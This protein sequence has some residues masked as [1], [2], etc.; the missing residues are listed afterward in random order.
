MYSQ[1]QWHGQPWGQA[2]AGPAPAAPLP[3]PWQHHA[4]GQAGYRLG[5]PSSSLSAP[6]PPP[7]PATARPALAACA[8]L[9]AVLAGGSLIN[10][11]QRAGPGWAPA[12]G[13]Q[14]SRGAGGIAATAATQSMRQL[15]ARIRGAE[16]VEVWAGGVRVLSAG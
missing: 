7:P 5:A 13:A 11:P 10:E 4:P 6:L 14:R 9:P 15:N 3:Q 12:A 1:Q 8:A 2:A 16:T